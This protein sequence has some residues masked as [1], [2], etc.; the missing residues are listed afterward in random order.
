MSNK[1]VQCQKEISIWL[2]LL[3]NL[4]TLLLIGIGAIIISF[5]STIGTIMYL[6][7]SIFSIIWFW[8]RI[9]TT[10]DFYDT[11]S[12]PC[13][14]GRIS[15]FLFKKQEHKSFKKAFKRNIIVLF[16]WWFI[17]PLLGMYIL[18]KEFSTLL[19][20]LVIAF[21]IVGFIIIPFISRFVGCKNCSEKENCPWMKSKK[22]S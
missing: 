13:G 15:S 21:C 3:D 20:S 9:C 7:Y 5:A 17:P 19:L 1:N 12:C 6:S 22:K 10:C 11:R 8:A 18:I 2:V 14:Y 16:P 4:P